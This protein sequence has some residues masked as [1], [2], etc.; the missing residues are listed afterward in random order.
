MQMLKGMGMTQNLQLGRDQGRLVKENPDADL[1]FLRQ[2]SESFFP[3]W[4]RLR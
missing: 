3:A 2:I 4:R 1:E